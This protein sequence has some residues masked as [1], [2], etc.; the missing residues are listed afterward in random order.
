M[1]KSASEPFS[2]VRGRPLSEN[3][4][5]MA[6]RPEGFSALARQKF[7][8]KKGLTNVPS[9]RIISHNNRTAQTSDGEKYPAR[10]TFREPPMVGT[11]RRAAGEWTS[12]GGPNGRKRRPSRDRRVSHP[13]S[14]GARMMVRVSEWTF[15]NVNLGGIAEAAA[16]VPCV[17]QNLFCS[18]FHPGSRQNSGHLPLKII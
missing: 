16:F 3:G 5:S 9:L 15:V 18:P 7:L 8:A 4:P 10:Q 2:P 12:E 11:G 13:L 1:V 17:G 14:I 6:A